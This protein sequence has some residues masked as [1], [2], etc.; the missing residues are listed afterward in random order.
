MS[1]RADSKESGETNTQ[2]SLDRMRERARARKS[3]GKG[4]KS[5]KDIAAS[6]QAQ[7]NEQVHNERNACGCGTGE[8]RRNIILAYVAHSHHLNTNDPLRVQINNYE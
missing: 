5:E 8:F 3:A 4:Q 1:S 2:R 6:Q 7:I